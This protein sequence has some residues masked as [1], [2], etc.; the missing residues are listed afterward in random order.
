MLAADG[1]LWKRQL[2][3]RKCSTIPV[4]MLPA[5]ESFILRWRP[6]GEAPDDERHVNMQRLVIVH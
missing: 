3:R 5:I 4:A 2:E 6:G 1:P